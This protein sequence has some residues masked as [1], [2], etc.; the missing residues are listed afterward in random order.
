VVVRTGDCCQLLYKA[1]KIVIVGP[2]LNLTCWSGEPKG[3]WTND[4]GDRFE[5]LGIIL[6]QGLAFA[7]LRR[8]ITSRA[9]AT[10]KEQIAEANDSVALRELV[11]EINILLDSIEQRLEEIGRGPSRAN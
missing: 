8:E 4:T 2:L 3:T 10:L 5:A 6:Q 9:L 1:T 11:I 7:I